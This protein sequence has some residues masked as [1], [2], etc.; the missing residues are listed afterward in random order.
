MSEQYVINIYRVASARWRWTVALPA[1][2]DF[3]E[4]QGSAFTRAGA[5]RAARRAVR[6]DRRLQSPMLVETILDEDGTR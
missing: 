5:L 2:A 6:Y 1:P 3:L 4:Y